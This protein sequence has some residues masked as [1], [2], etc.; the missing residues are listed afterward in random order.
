MPQTFKLTY[1]NMPGREEVRENIKKFDI[2]QMS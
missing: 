1:F 2:P